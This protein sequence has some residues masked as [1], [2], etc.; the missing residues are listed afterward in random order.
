MGTGNTPTG[1]GWPA[2]LLHWLMAAVIVFQLGL[3]FWMANFVG[4]QMEQFALIQ[5]HKS[6][7]FV[8]FTLALIR[9]A[10]RLIHRAPDLPVGTSRLEAA[11]ARGAHLSLYLLMLALPVTGWLMVSASPLQDLGARNEVFGLFALPDPFRPGSE[12]LEDLFRS[13]HT[14]CAVALTLILAGHAGA[15]LRHHFLRRD[16]VLR[17]MVL[18]R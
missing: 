7:G 16:A 1:W 9:V 18:G 11:L 13:V 12:G 14:W 17:R 3:G 5:T 15:A 10:W 6:W 2:R 8:I 4:D